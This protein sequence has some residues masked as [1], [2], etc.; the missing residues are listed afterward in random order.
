M[1]F[2]AAACNSQTHSGDAVSA[3]RIPLPAVVKD[4]L[5]LVNDMDLP[6]Q[7]EGCACYYARNPDLFKNKQFVVAF[8]YSGSAYLTVNNVL[9]EL[10]NTSAEKPMDGFELK[11][12]ENKDYIL[13]VQT[14]AG[15][16]T[17][18]EVFESFGNMTLVNKK[19]GKTQSVQLH[20][21]CGC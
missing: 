21:E 20:G 12:Y 13:M 16:K 11:R 17:G 3:S 4:S 14:K 15:N 19:N 9:N 1:L 10:K 7:L 18:D 2:L 8:S 5:A 6:K